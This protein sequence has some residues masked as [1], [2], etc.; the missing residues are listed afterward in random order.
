MLILNFGSEELKKEFR[1]KR[2]YLIVKKASYSTIIF[3]VIISISVFTA[4]MIVTDSYNS[5]VEQ[6]FFITRNIRGYTEQLKI[7]NNN[8]RSVN[9]V[10]SSY[11]IWT[12][13]IEAASNIKPDGTKI[14]YLKASS[15]DKKVSIKGLANTRESLLEIKKNMETNTFF[16]NIIFPIKN[17]LDKNTTTFDIDANFDIKKIQS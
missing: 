11:L 13:L 1:L 16:N 8:L 4:K 14:I 7:V 15:K 12:K 10:Q 5:V 6:S 2:I 17:I 9:E 3:A